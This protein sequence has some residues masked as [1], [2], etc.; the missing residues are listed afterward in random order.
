MGLPEK[1]F[2]SINEIAE[3]WK[4]SI[5]HVLQ[6]AQ[7]FA[8]E[9][10]FILELCVIGTGWIA[11]TFDLCE[12]EDLLVDAQTEGKMMSIEIE[13][14]GPV[15]L[16]IMDIGIIQNSN[17]V[18]LDMV[19][20]PKRENCYRDYKL[21]GKYSPHTKG[22]NKITVSTSDLII[23]REERN[24]FENRYKIGLSG[25]KSQDNID[26]EKEIASQSSVFNLLKG[27][28]HLY[29]EPAIF[30]DLKKPRSKRLTEIQ[31]DLENKGYKFDAKTLRKYLKNLPD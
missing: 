8:A 10:G 24:R 25:Q 5:D 26:K 20:T 15:A 6:L 18:E 16:E 22:M 31:V 21:I 13:I 11:E 23:T 28:I 17:I 7:Q 1:S 27:L 4:C 14:Y 2:Y 3:R 9:G 12:D 19:S 29:Y 30:E